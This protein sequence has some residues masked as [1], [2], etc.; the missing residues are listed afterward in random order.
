MKLKLTIYH[1]D[2]VNRDEVSAI[3]TFLYWQGTKYECVVDARTALTKSNGKGLAVLDSNG[4]LIATGFHELYKY[5]NDNGLF[6]I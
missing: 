3:V 6:L 5:F 4:S 1:W 2:H